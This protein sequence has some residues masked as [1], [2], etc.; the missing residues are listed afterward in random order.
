MHKRLCQ[1]S[2]SFSLGEQTMKLLTLS[3]M[4][5]AATLAG[6]GDNATPTAAPA[7]TPAPTPTAATPAAPAA[8][9]A[10]AAADAASAMDAAKLKAD[11]L[12]TD[13]AN[14]VKENKLDLADKAIAG[15]DELKPKLP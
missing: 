10:A 7:P 2:I 9:A 1:P 14:Y 6:C 5:L 4:L 12:L 15:L 13:A 11:Q 3:T 8:P